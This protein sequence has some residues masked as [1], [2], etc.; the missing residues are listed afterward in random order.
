M[1]LK[2]NKH[3]EAA[4]ITMVDLEQG[5]NPYR[6]HKPVNEAF[7]DFIYWAIYDYIHK[8]HNMI[9]NDYGLVAPHMMDF[10]NAEEDVE[11]EDPNDD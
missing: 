6:A 8:P 11:E 2:L 10:L 1:R 3:L 9:R 4:F 7:N 5:R